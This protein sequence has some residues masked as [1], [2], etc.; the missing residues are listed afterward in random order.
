MKNILFATLFLAIMITIGLTIVQKRQVP[1]ANNDQYN[2]EFGSIIENYILNE[3][4]NKFYPTD[5]KFVV[6][7]IFGAENKEQFLFLYLHVL[8]VGYRNENNTLKKSAGGYGRLVLKLKRVNDERKYTVFESISPMDG[9]HY[10]D[11][12]KLIFPKKYHK[13]ALDDRSLKLNTKLSK[14]VIEYLRENNMT[15]DET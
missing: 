11:S 9:D 6:Y 2:Q 7:D 5:E 1:I 13:A 3:H 14:K 10:F 15:I 8:F 4:F 12:I